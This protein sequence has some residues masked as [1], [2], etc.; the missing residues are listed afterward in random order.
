MVTDTPEE[1]R[2][3][4]EDEKSLILST[5]VQQKRKRKL[6]PLKYFF[7]A[8]PL[9]ACW[10]AHTTHLYLNYSVILM[11]PKYL[12]DIQGKALNQSN[13]IIVF[14]GFSIKEIGDLAALP[15]VMTIFLIL[16]GGF[17]ADKL[18][19][20]GYNLLTIRRTMNFI[21]SVVPGIICLCFYFVTCNIF[22]AMAI[23]ITVQTLMGFQHPSS[24]VILVL[25][26][27]T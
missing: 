18:Q 15:Q 27:L 14:S 20:L 23:M 13:K 26:F 7:T 21:G 16:S 6:P 19:N 22:A 9:V 4:S 17:I 8:L 12:R 1:H 25:E 2:L 10:V 11:F 5:R 24:K 3:I